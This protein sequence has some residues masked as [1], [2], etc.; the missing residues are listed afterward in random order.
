MRPPFHAFSC[1]PSRRYMDGERIAGK[2]KVPLVHIP[3]H[4]SMQPLLSAHLPILRENCDDPSTRFFIRWCV[5]SGT[6]SDFHD[7][8]DNRRYE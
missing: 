1:I 5:M 8:H 3:N 7:D 4:F 2:R 6:E